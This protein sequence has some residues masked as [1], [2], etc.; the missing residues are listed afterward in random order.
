M[1]VKLIKNV[2]VKGHAGIKKGDVIDLLPGFASTLVIEGCAEFYEETKY[3]PT[4]IETRE[5][6]IQNREPVIEEMPQRKPSS[7]RPAK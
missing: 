7:R 1:K 3:E 4:R 5:P 6:V 2:I